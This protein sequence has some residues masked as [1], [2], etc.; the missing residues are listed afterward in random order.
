MAPDFRGEIRMTRNEWLRLIAILLVLFG[1]WLFS[2]FEWA[3]QKVPGAMRG[4]ARRDANYAA[5]LLIRRLGYPVQVAKDPSM[6]ARQ[7]VNATLVANNL[8]PETVAQR[9]EAPIVEWVKKGGH[10]FIVV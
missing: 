3:E 10:L 1:S 2:N 5:R 8:F 4:E 6:L 9:I 7:P